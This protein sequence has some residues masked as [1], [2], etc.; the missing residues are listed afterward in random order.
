[1]GLGVLPD[2]QTPS[3]SGIPVGVNRQSDY[4]D[5]L[6]GQEGS[7]RIPS[8]VPNLCLVNKRSECEDSQDVGLESSHHLKS[9]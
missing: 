6:R 5:K 1:M 3:N 4:G 8:H 9:A 2:Y 7:P